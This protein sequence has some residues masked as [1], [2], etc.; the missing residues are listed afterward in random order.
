[1]PKID[2]NVYQGLIG[3]ESFYKLGQKTVEYIESNWS[4]L[5]WEP[6]TKNI[7]V[8]FMQH[9]LQLRSTRIAATRMAPNRGARTMKT[10]VHVCDETNQRYG[11]IFKDRSTADRHS[12]EDIR[13]QPYSH[14]TSFSED[15]THVL[16]VREDLKSPNVALVTTAPSSPRMSL[17]KNIH[18]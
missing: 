2:R 8:A 1:M 13:A 7:F 10:E 15:D 6:K 12:R 11:W 17:C 5:T 3:K 4:R 16:P 18:K 14:S 9:A